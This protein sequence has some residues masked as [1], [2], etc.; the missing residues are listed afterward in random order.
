MIFEAILGIIGLVLIYL[1][2][3]LI[4]LV[5]DDFGSGYEQTEILVAKLIDLTKPYSTS[6]IY[7]DKFDRVFSVFIVISVVYIDKIYSQRY[8]S[9][10]VGICA[11]MIFLTV[12]SYA[13]IPVLIKIKI[14]KIRLSIKKNFKKR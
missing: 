6:N 7:T 3:N 11:S 10:Y 5:S 13:V 14:Q 12:F 1:L 2:W 9:M 8:G 4:C